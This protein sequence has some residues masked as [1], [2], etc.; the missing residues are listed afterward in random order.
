VDLPE[1]LRGL[2]QTLKNGA[3]PAEVLDNAIKL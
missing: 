1:N 2:R 3:D